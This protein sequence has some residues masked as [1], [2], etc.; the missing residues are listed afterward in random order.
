MKL[1][2]S[3]RSPYVRKVMIVAHETGLADQIDPVRTVVSR[4]QLNPD[5]IKEFPVGRIPALVLE[6]GIVLSGSFAICDYLDSLHGGRKL[7][8]AAGAPRWRELELHGVADGALDILLSWRGEL[9]KP[10]ALRS[11]ALVEASA[12][13]IRH[14]LDWLNR[15]AAGFGGE[16]YGIGQITVG[17]LLDYLD[18]RFPG[19]DWRGPGPHLRQWHK[20]F[21]E[22]PSSKATEIVHYE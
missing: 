11:A 1:H 5:L 17:V 21:A 19:L 18:F 9:M 2:W 22:R 14:C 13:K 4:T 12:G 8:S 15:R 10:E 20:L 16:E 7:I 3:S 6:N